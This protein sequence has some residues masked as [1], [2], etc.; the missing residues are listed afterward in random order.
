MRGLQTFVFELCKDQID[1]E[2]D[3]FCTPHKR[4]V[5]GCG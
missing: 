3:S 4:E 1:W 5:G 2:R